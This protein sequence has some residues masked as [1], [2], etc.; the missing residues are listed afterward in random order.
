MI[1]FY[2]LLVLVHFFSELL[3]H[4]IV[5][6]QLLTAH[7]ARVRDGK[8]C[9]DASLVVEV[10]S[11]YK[12]HQFSATTMVLCQSDTSTCKTKLERRDFYLPI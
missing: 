1:L 10:L 6:G 3:I 2:K 12:R 8:P 4:R 7:Q 11:T 9:A 5:S